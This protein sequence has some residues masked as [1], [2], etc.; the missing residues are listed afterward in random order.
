MS[1]LSF[2][3]RDR[4]RRS[5]IA[6]A[7]LLPSNK[8]KAKH[9]KSDFQA[10]SNFIGRNPYFRSVVHNR[11][12]INRFKISS[13]RS[14]FP[15]NGITSYKQS[16]RSSFHH[17][18][19]EQEDQIMENF[20]DEDIKPDQDSIYNENC[21]DI[22]RG[23]RVED[24]K[25]VA[26]SDLTLKAMQLAVETDIQL[27]STLY[28]VANFL[29]QNQDVCLM[30]DEGTDK[31]HAKRGSLGI[32]NLSFLEGAI[33]NLRFGEEDHGKNKSPEKHKLSVQLRLLANT[34]GSTQIKV[35]SWE[36]IMTQLSE[37]FEFPF[38][39]H[40]NESKNVVVEARISTKSQRD[41]S[42][43]SV[44]KY[45][46]QIT[47]ATRSRNII[48]PRERWRQISLA[49]TPSLF[50]RKRDSHERSDQ[51]E[52]LMIID[53]IK[54]HEAEQEIRTEE[55]IESLLSA[56]E[57]EAST[58]SELS[59]RPLTSE[60]MDIVQ[61]ALSGPGNGT[62]IIAQT[63]TDTCQRDS[64]RK[65]RPGCWLND[66]VIHFFLQ[67]LTKRDAI[68]CGKEKS[69]KRSHFFKSFFITKLLDEACGYR[70]QNVKRWSK[71]VPGKD[72]FSLHNI[73]FPVNVGGVHWCCAVIYMEE[74]RIQFYDSMGGSGMRYLEGLQKYL[75]DEH[76]DKKKSKL[77]M[78]DWTLVPS[79]ASTPQQENS[80]DCGVFSCMF[81]DFLSRDVPLTFTQ[82]HV[83]QCRERIALSIMIGNALI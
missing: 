39:S 56:K 82:E 19:Q 74:H 10:R 4:K 32:W 64:I 60:E 50:V 83:T 38:T 45:L 36:E 63:D 79:Q 53:R 37:M 43:D 69:K 62:E 73:I 72:I 30:H 16:K 14:S 26:I 80:F 35:S 33:R 8:H 3:E 23:G 75:K 66:E 29:S 7:T 71:K 59:L 17:N 54:S 22:S 61:S 48:S 12:R 51:N 55:K 67:M 11:S 13:K 46:D 21:R 44:N 76:L 27:P 31:D 42:S 77:D 47:K 6:T 9:K 70:Y 49:P 81:A 2:F 52:K 24:K 68:I 57:S 34:V 58:S 15:Y 18:E 1:W 41:P 28:A 25:K 65:L 5:L 20:V 40:E 78:S